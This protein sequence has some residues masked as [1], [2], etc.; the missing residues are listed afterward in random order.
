M[1]VLVTGLPG[2]TGHYVKQALED[3]GHVVI[4]LES[5]LRDAEGLGKEV[6]DHTPEAVLHLAAQA[7]VDHGQTSDFYEVNVIGTDNLLNALVDH[8]P[9]LK[10]VLV[11]SSANIYGNQSEGAL[12]E[13]RSPAPANHYAIS[14]L[15]TEHLSHLFFDRLPISITRPFNY[16][17]VGQDE[18]FLIPKIV[19]HFRDQAG[20]IELGNIDVLR[21]FG[22]V[23]SVA[24][25]YRR[26]LE[27]APVGQTLNICTGRPRSL[28]Q[29]VSL[30]EELSGHHPD[31]KINPR[32]VR[33]NEVR[34][35]VGDN[36][37][38]RATIG[39]WAV[40][41]LRDTLSWMLNPTG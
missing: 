31:I 39:D 27:A 4:G 8:A 19:R 6:K 34:T 35:L 40:P 30:C 24:D 12:S 26:L 41:D 9:G 37:R 28:M 22:D 14:K 23:R 38:L 32:F 16:T 1:R 11:A 17:G 21:D 18:K 29:I 5:D 36:S 33:K 20:V 7:F 3:A 10:S 13:E 25:I 2:F 15:A